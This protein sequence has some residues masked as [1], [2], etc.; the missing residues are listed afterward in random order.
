MRRHGRAAIID[1]VNK[2]SQG[3]FIDRD[4]YISIY[5]TGGEIA[6]HGANRRLWGADWSKVKDTDGRHFVSEMVNM[7]KARGEGWVD[8]KWVHP[9][10]KE[11]MVKSAYFEICDD[12]V[13]ACGFYKT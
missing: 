10:T 13:I 11:T 1:E 8:Y 6:A 7:A 5:A 4:L 9:V 3:Q 2:L 12:L